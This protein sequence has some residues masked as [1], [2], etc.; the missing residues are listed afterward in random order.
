[1]RYLLALLLLFGCAKNA[2]ETAAQ[3]S[4]NQL[5][6]IQHKIEKECPTANFNEEIKALESGIINQL[7]T[8]EAQK[9]TLKERNNTLLVILF[10]I[11]VV[12]GVSKFAKRI[13]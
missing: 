3:N 4:L 12:F 2:S 9:D 8:C 5:H 11:I 13:V 10:G 7:E 6:V 1:M